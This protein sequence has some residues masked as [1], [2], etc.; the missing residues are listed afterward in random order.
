MFQCWV[1]VQ[2]QVDQVSH[3]QVLVMQVVYHQAIHLIPHNLE[4]H[5]HLVQQ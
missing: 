2:L 3:H 1:V 4:V 5:L